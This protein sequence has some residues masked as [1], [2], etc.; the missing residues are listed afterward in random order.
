MLLELLILG[1]AAYG[2]KASQRKIDFDKVIKQFFG[3]SHNQQMEV[4]SKTAAEPEQSQEDKEANR[5]LT[6][7]TVSLGLATAGALLY[8][9]LGVLSVPFWIY[10]TIPV[11][12]NTYKSL[13]QEGK[14]HVHTLVAIT[15]ITCLLSRYY[16]VGSL[17]AWFYVLSRKL[18]I[19]VKNQSEQS[20][21]QVF[22]QHPLFVWVLVNGIEVK[23]PFESVQQGNLVVVNAGETIPVD[24]FIT[25]GMASVDQHLLTGEA[26]PAE[27]GVDDQVFASTVILKGRLCIK[28]EKAGDETIVAKIGQILNQMAHFKTDW[29]LR[30]ENMTAK[31]V[32]PTLIAGG[33]S[34]PILG[35]IGAATVINAHFGY[36]MS[37]VS[38]IGVMSYFRLLSQNGLLI[39]DG[40]MLD[41]LSKVDTIVFDKTGTLTIPLPHVGQIYTCLDY[42]ENEVLAYAAAAEYRQTHPIALAILE[43]AQARQHLDIPNIDDAEYE[44]GY[45][46]KVTIND[47]LIE[48][49]SHRFMEHEGMTI[50]PSI[51]QAEELGHSQGHSLVMV[52]LDNKV[53]GAIELLPTVRPEASAIIHKLRQHY[54]KSMYIISGDHETPTQKLAQDL[55][56]EH[57][58]ANVLPQ[59]KAEIIE[60]LQASG[61]VV[62]YIGDGIN[63]SIAL[64]Q[65]QVSISLRGASTV[66]TDAA[67]IILMNE[68]LS[69]LCHLFDFAQKFEATMTSSF[70]IMLAT[71]LIGM[72]GAFV[73]DFELIDT[74]L[75]KQAGL[76]VG[77]TN[78][79]WPL[80]KHQGEASKSIDEVWSGSPSMTNEQKLTKSYSFS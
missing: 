30:A 20:F 21:V 14:V 38:S 22:G 60:Q 49:G 40:R 67:Q 7:S 27:K 53:I 29:Q 32:V 16:V 28:V 13:W 72:S 43:E 17:D 9:P 48:V 51:K 55:G 39:K 73:L 19:K 31:T 80:T 75:L 69:Q 41:L 46:L 77:L 58:F 34:L 63:D 6:V 57:Y 35:P 33:L 78:A 8:P 66:A 59:N 56:I 76:M 74:I 5:D 61:K 65:A 11:F 25:E 15:L 64:K 50:P 1:G 45:G 3:E 37:I 26:Q 18:L 52:A 10:V 12:K 36:R 42:E 23:T 24:G 62:C 4:S 71:T 47:L 2:I 70:N 44:I 68:N 79:T 54:N